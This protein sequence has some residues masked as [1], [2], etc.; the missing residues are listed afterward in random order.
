[1]WELLVFSLPSG[2]RVYH[3]RLENDGTYGSTANA[4]RSE[5]WS[6][7]TMHSKSSPQ[8]SNSKFGRYFDHNSNYWNKRTHQATNDDTHTRMDHEDREEAG[9]GIK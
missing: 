5:K 4:S 2:T 3:Q 1:M 9:K 6:R 7:W 8:M